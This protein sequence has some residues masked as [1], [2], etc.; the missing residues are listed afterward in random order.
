M[1]LTVL[2]E[3]W[4][5]LAVAQ[6]KALVNKLVRAGRAMNAGVDIVT[7]NADDV[8][9]EKMKNNIGLKFAF[10][11]TDIVEIKKILTFFG[12]D[13]EDEDNQKKIKGLEN[14]ECLFQDLYGRTAVIYIDP[15]F[16]WLF[17]AFDTRP[18]QRVEEEVI[19]D[20]ADVE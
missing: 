6:G 18:P 9:D 19:L 7:Q 20:E 11:S 3:A 8:G 17:D 14:G 4:S 2:D 1:I 12:L 15:V 5:L 10:R 16:N 13:P